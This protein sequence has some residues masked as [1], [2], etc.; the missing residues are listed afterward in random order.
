MP[1]HLGCR[2]AWQADASNLEIDVYR[3]VLGGLFCVLVLTSCTASRRSWKVDDYQRLTHRTFHDV[4]IFHVPLDFDD[5]DY[6]RLHAAI[7]YATNAVRGRHQRS[8]LTHQPLL[9]QAARLYAQRLVSYAF[10]DHEDP[11]T[12]TLRSVDDRVRAAGVVNPSSSENLAIYFAIR[13]RPRERV[14]RL[15]GQ[16]GQFSRTPNGPAIPPHTYL[17]FAQTVVDFW[18]HSPNHR[19]AILAP[20]ALELG[21]GAAFFWDRQG[22]PKFK[23]V[24]VFQW[25]EPVQSATTSGCAS[26]FEPYSGCVTP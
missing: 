4:A 14:F 1:G 8:A 21:C 17:S 11:Y 9:E 23:L 3:L 13:Y 18:M 22:F 6:G 24:Q 10:F 16:R 12:A 20:E 7:F 15:R 2:L 5:L 19:D 25:Y 26:L